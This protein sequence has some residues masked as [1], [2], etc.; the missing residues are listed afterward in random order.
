MIRDFKRA[1]RA[2]LS[3]IIFASFS[4]SGCSNN[5]VNLTILST[6]DFHG[7]LES[8]IKDPETGQD[9]GS[10]ASLAAT[11]REERSMNPD[12]TIYLDGGDSLMGTALSN[13]SKGRAVVALMNMIGLDATAIGNHEFDFGVDVR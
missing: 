11:I 8:T 1:T 6:N 5:L 7:A 2:T 10:A 13:F 4:L 12:G 3:A 9:L